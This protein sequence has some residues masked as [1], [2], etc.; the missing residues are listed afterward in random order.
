MRGGAPG[1][2]LSSGSGGVLSAP[3]AEASV[4]DARRSSAAPGG[5]ETIHTPLATAAASRMRV[6]GR[7]YVPGSSLISTTLLDDPVESAASC[8]TSS[9]AELASVGCRGGGGDGG[10]GGGDGGGGE[11]GGGDGG[12]GVGGGDGGGGEGGGGDGG[13]GEGGG[14]DGGGDGGGGDGGGGD[15]GGGDG[16]GSGGGLGCGWALASSSGQN[17][18]ASHGSQ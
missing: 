1:A 18:W 11:G 3:D 6:D 9:A 12:G 16:G 10:G 17:S 2:V 5:S 13:G 8:A 14:G 15:G 7:S 4:D